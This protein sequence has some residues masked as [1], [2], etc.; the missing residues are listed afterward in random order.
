MTHSGTESQSIQEPVIEGPLAHELDQYKGRWVAV[1]QDH[2]VA[3]GDSAGEALAAAQAKRIT[4][5][6]IFRVPTNPNR[7][8][9][10]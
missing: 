8:A 7:I 10:Y 3:A 4:D 5:P 1:F 2:V 9:F 6:L